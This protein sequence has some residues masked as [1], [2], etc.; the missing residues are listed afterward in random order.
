MVP[1][2]WNRLESAD[3]T[4]AGPA[5]EWSGDL[6]FAPVR[7]RNGVRSAGGWGRFPTAG[8]WPTLQAAMESCVELWVSPL[9]DFRALSET[10]MMVSNYMGRAAQDEGGDP[11]LVSIGLG[12]NGLFFKIGVEPLGEE[13]TAFDVAPEWAQGEPHHVAVAWWPNKGRYTVAVFLDGSAQ[14]YD[15]SKVLHI[16]GSANESTYILSSCSQPPPLPESPPY[17]ITAY[18]DVFID[19]L[20]V[21]PARKADFSDRFFDGR[22]KRPAKNRL[23]SAEGVAA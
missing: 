7:H 1:S 3:R 5:T 22:D 8:V 20:K 12:P 23:N 2:Y 6:V 14:F 21:W 16:T 13:P 19:N 15:E 17:I 9:C 11:N 10:K 18:Q 4:E